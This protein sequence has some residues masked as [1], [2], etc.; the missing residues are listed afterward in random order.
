M[1]GSAT[2]S[3]YLYGLRIPW[4]QPT[5]P[6]NDPFLSTLQD[7]LRKR[8]GWTTNAKT[9]YNCFCASTSPPT[10]NHRI[11]IALPV[12]VFGYVDVCP[13]SLSQLHSPFS[14]APLS[15][16]SQLS[17]NQH[18]F[19][20]ALFNEQNLRMIGFIP[21]TPTIVCSHVLSPFPFL[22]FCPFPFHFQK[23]DDQ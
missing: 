20:R 18:V 1:K 22:F 21:S 19:L 16:V 6:R 3:S 14:L 2:C 12:V 8:L 23:E 4:L 11:P 5:G 13:L 15:A 17:S 10:P 7:M 9:G